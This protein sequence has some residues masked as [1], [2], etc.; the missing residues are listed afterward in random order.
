MA[1]CSTSRP[2]ATFLS[3]VT[4]DHLLVGRELG[5]DHLRGE[6]PAAG[7]EDEMPLALVEG[8]RLLA[9]HVLDE[10]GE[11]GDGLA[12]HQDPRGLRAP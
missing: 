1:L 2:T 8:H 6:R 11:L 7:G 5:L 3:P 12:G 10:P 4:R 9:A